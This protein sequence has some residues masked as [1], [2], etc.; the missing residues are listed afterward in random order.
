ML[1]E[2]LSIECL[3]LD[4]LGVLKASVN[5][6][7]VLPLMLIEFEFWTKSYLLFVSV[8]EL[9]KRIEL[10]SFVLECALFTVE[11]GIFKPFWF[12]N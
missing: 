7:P 6:Y 2:L 10:D 4:A 1:I 5:F 8:I 9:F 3:L 12:P 11:I